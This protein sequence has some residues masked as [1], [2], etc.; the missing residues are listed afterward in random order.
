MLFVD[1]EMADKHQMLLRLYDQEAKDNKRL[2]M[3]NEQ[4]V[5]KLSQE[6]IAPPPLTPNPVRRAIN[7]PSGIKSAPGTPLVTRRRFFAPC[8]ATRPLSQGDFDGF[9]ADDFVKEEDDGDEKEYY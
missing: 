1:R 4:L 9:T 6:G 3:D 2:S 7:T 5:W 8:S